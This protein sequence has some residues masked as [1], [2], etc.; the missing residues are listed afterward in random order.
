MLPHLRQSPLRQSVEFGLLLISVSLAAG[1]QEAVLADVRR[2]RSRQTA[3]RADMADQIMAGTQRARM[4]LAA[5]RRSVMAIARDLSVGANGNDH[6]LTPLE[7]TIIALVL[8]GY[9]SK[10]TGQR[11]GI[12]GHRARQNLGNIIAKLGVSN[13][14][15]L[16][17]FALHNHLVDPI[18]ISLLLSRCASARQPELGGREG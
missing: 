6:G 11:I 16:V 12:S 10:E 3:S 7:K 17:L 9:T 5:Q 14:F 8:A 2:N 18:Q 1:P 15:E 13:R 4:G